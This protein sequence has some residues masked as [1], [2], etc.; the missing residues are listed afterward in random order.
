MTTYSTGN[1]I[2]STSPKD[3]YDNAENFDELVNSQTKTSHPDRLGNPRWT[4]HGIE[5]RVDEFLANSGYAPANGG[6][7]DYDADSPFSINSYNE[8]VIKDGIPYRLSPAA[9]IPY[10]TNGNWAEQ[11]GDFIA[12]EA[13]PPANT[14]PVNRFGVSHNNRSAADI[15]SDAI[16]AALVFCAETGQDLDLGSGVIF[17]SKPIVQRGRV[18]VFGRGVNYWQ[19]QYTGDFAPQA[20]T[21]IVMVGTGPKDQTLFV[22][23]SC[24]KWGA[25][26]INPSPVAG[27]NDAEYRLES[28]VTS[29]PDA[30]TRSLRPFSAA[31]TVKGANGNNQDVWGSSWHGFRIMP[32]AGGDDGMED[33]RNSDR[34]VEKP[35]SSGD[36]DVGFYW[37]AAREIDSQH[38]QAVGQW[39]IAGGLVAPHAKVSEIGAAAYN[40]TFDNCVFN[41]LMIRSV[42]SAPVVATTPTTV[43]IPWADDHPF[44]ADGD[45]SLILSTQGRSGDKFTYTGMQKITGGSY[46]ILRLTGV[47]PD[48]TAQA[49]KIA[50]VDY[51]GGGTSE[52]KFENVEIQGFGHGSLE[53]SENVDLGGVGLNYFDRPLANLEISGNELTELDF[54]VNCIITGYDTVAAHMHDCRNVI[55]PTFWEMNNAGRIIASGP[56]STNTHSVC[57]FAAS[58]TMNILF[59]PFGSTIENGSLDMRPYITEMNPAIRFTDPSDEG[60]ITPVRLRAQ[61]FGSPSTLDTLSALAAPKGG[62][63]AIGRY[64]GQQ[65]FFD[66]SANDF[67][68]AL[69][70]EESRDLVR[71]RKPIIS[72]TRDQTTIGQQFNEFETTWSTGFLSREF[73]DISD[74]S[75]ASF[76]PARA[77]GLLFVTAYNSEALPLNNASAMI[78]FD[79]GS[80]L[81]IV[82]LDHSGI[83]GNVAVVTTDVTGTSGLDGNL[84]VSA[85]AGQIKIENRLGG[86]RTIRVTV[87]G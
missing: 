2:G 17:C 47:I 34:S 3:L 49:Y 70:Y 74:D 56:R 27:Y 67:D 5:K 78:Y 39:R 14:V 66:P 55:L 18:N 42:D 72:N 61:R 37:K 38:L 22:V 7:N 44:G 77:G 81:N 1:P 62:R 16:N 28:F 48:P 11:S 54:S 25:G 9:T 83:G 26:R 58:E 21:A 4:W 84:T 71:V 30:G 68:A 75:V 15:N 65:G 80:S 20:A 33:V 57:G 45:L 53:P 43:D 40:T 87:L 8:Y 63:A 46:D 60:M 36:W 35:L 29:S 85:Q 59:D 6:L 73:T 31:W 10:Q 76:T 19:K 24:S 32:D 82:K 51:K 13:N 86:D 52:M 64:T 69:Y 50:R 12:L 41:R 79:V 23:S